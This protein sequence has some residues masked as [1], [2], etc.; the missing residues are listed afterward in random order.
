[1]DD[2][3]PWLPTSAEIGAS[4]NLLVVHVGRDGSFLESVDFK[5][6]YTGTA[7]QVLSKDELATWHLFQFDSIQSSLFKTG[8]LK[9]TEVFIIPAVNLTYLR[10]QD[11]SIDQHESREP[12]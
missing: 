3:E 6:Q 2:G 12:D 8:K 10:T 5:P 7:E 4:W 11:Q 9:F 1:M